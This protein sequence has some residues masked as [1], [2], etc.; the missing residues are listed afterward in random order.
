MYTHK[1]RRNLVTVDLSGFL[2]R[3]WEAVKPR[4]VKKPVDIKMHGIHLHK[5]DFLS[6]LLR[7]SMKS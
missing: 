7:D 5:I 4:S 2:F 1:Q 6:S 3:K